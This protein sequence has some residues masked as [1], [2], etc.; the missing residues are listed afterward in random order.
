VNQIYT[1]VKAEIV[2]DIPRDFDNA[3]LSLQ[4]CKSQLTSV[5]NVV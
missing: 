5:K 4:H 3:I 2:K 1:V